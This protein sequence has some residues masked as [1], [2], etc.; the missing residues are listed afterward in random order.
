ML[1]IPN[2]LNDIVFESDARFDVDD[3]TS[4]ASIYLKGDAVATVLNHVGW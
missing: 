2:P 4:Q 3:G 1:I